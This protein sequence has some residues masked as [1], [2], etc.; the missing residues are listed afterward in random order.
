MYFFKILCYHPA[1]QFLLTE[2]VNLDVYYFQI[3]LIHNLILKF[4][5][6]ILIIQI[7]ILNFKLIHFQDQLFFI[8]FIKHFFSIIL[9]LKN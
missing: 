8:T 9:I 4:F 5:F 6:H 7:L 3:N 2:K 1:L